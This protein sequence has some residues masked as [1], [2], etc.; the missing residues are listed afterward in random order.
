MKD[1]IV[2]LRP[3]HSDDR[4]LWNAIFG[5]Y[6]YPVLLAAH[7]FGLFELLHQK[8]RSGKDICDSL[9]LS[10]RGVDAMIPVL[11][12]MELVRRCDD[13]FEL[14][15]VAETYLVRGKPTYFGDYLELTIA[16]ASIFSLER[17]ENAIRTDLPQVY[18]GGREMFTVHD[19]QDQLARDFTRSMH[20]SSMA[21]ALTWPALL[22]LS[23]HEVMLDIGGGSGAHCIGATTRWPKLRALV[24]DVVPVCEVAEAIVAQHG[25]ETRVRTHVGDMWSDPF[26][27]ADLHFYGMIHHDWPPEKGRFLSQKSFDAMDSGGRIVIHDMFYDDAKQGPFSAAAFSL[28]MLLWTEGRQYSGAE[29]SQMLY[30]VGFRDI[31]VKPAFGHWGIVTGRKP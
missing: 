16:N 19:E 15:E 24:F 13:C 18:G 12:S 9:A 4:P 11:A 21:P 25:L 20:A 10:P 30:D 2:S 23:S 26:P 28:V 6:A 14:T 8:P 7:K 22:D 27:V 3:P 5:M 17:I 29:Y 31:E 1:T